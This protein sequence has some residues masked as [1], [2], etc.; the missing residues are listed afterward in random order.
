MFSTV[1]C[2][3]RERRRYGRPAQQMR[4]LDFALWFLILSS[5]FLSSPNLSGRIVDVYHTCRAYTRCGLSANLAALLHGNQVSVSQT[6]ALNRGRHLCS[7]GRPSRWAL[8]GYIFATRRVSSIGVFGDF[9]YVMIGRSINVALGCGI[10][11]TNDL[12]NRALSHAAEA[13]IKLHSHINVM[14]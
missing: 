7:A 1:L 14:F 9:R 4:T 6:A 13:N 3:R 2:Q 8:S 10:R 5:I 12:G 11:I